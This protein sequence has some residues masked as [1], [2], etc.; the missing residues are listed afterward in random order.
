MFDV[1]NVSKTEE[2]RKFGVTS[3]HLF[4]S[5]VIKWT[6]LRA[7][8][9]NLSPFKIHDFRLSSRQADNQ[10]AGK[11]LSHMQTFGYHGK[12]CLKY[13]ISYNMDEEYCKLWYGIKVLYVS[14]DKT[15]IL[16]VSEKLPV[17]KFRYFGKYIIQLYG[18]F[19]INVS[20]QR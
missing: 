19:Y 3:R 20:G 12:T 7:G 9:D 18:Y 1:K 11:S 15:Y 2:L 13:V 4:T 8:H 17:S 16:S 10:L 6:T 14:D 5:D